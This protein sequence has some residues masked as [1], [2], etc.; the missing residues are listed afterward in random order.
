MSK[1]V[2]VG[3]VVI[4]VDPVAK[5]HNAIVTAVWSQTCINVVLVNDDPNMTDSYG[6]QIKRETS[7]NYKDTPGLVHGMYWMFPD[8][9][10]NPI[11]KPL[12]S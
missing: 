11:V 4:W 2:H 1:E 5:P 3:D 12:E 10:P 7:Q 6:R 9:E 8:D